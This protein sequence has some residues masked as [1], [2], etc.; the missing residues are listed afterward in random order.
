MARVRIFQ[1]SCND[2]DVIGYLSALDCKLGKSDKNQYL[3][4]K[5]LFVPPGRHYRYPL[6]EGNQLSG[7]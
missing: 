4:C 2:G 5:E 6:A 1:G 3:R 7:W